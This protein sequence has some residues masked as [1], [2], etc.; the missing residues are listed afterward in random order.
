VHAGHTRPHSTVY[1][2]LAPWLRSHRDVDARFSGSDEPVLEALTVAARSALLLVVGAHRVG[3]YERPRPN[4]R[5]Q[6]IVHHA[7][8]PVLVTRSV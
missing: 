5:T 8:S 2:D 7:A 6:L 4:P 1:A 3:W